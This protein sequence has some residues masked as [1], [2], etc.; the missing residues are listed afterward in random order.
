MNVIVL[1]YGSAGARHARLL[2]ELGCRVCVVSGRDIGGYEC[3]S[4]LELALEQRP[5]NYVVVANKTSDHYAALVRLAKLGFKGIV[6]VEKPLFHTH[7]ALPP[8]NFAQVFVAYN[9][10]FHPVLQK[11]RKLLLNEI[12]ICA[13]IYAGQYLP[14]WRPKVDYR[15]TYSASK[16]AGGGVLRDLSHELDYANWIFGRCAAIAALGGHLSG[17]EIDSDDVYSLMM[18]T[19]RCPILNIQLNYLDQVSRREMLV[20]TAN[21]TIR[22]DLVH[23]TLQVDQASEEMW[24][25]RDHSYRQQHQAIIGRRLDSVCSVAEGLEILSLIESAEWASAGREW[26]SR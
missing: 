23:G 18:V 20:S 11:L 25:E 6:L 14:Q 13:S 1:G 5:A 4:E 12:I 15:K 26:V 3:Y 2:T 10:R 7:L 19:E 9:L 21:H 22:A 24:V 8:N 16:H 17:L